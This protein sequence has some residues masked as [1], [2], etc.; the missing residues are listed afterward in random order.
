[1]VKLTVSLGSGATP[2]SETQLQL[3]KKVVTEAGVDLG[4]SEDGKHGGWRGGTVWLVPTDKSIED[5]KPIA[6]RQL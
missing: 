2:I 3:V 6:T 1:V 4:G 5:W